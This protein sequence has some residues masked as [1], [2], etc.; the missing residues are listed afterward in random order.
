MAADPSQVPT[1]G[2]FLYLTLAS[3]A[4][5]MTVTA[6]RWAIVDTLHRR[7]GLKAPELDFAKL[8][9]R[10]DAFELLI[11][12]HYRHYQYYANMAV[13]TVMAY[14]GFRAHHGWSVHFG[15]VESLFVSLEILFLGT[16]RDTLAK[17]YKRAELLLGTR[18]EAPDHRPDSFDS[19]C[20]TKCRSETPIAR[21][22][23]R[24]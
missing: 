17:Y 10:V 2:G 1:I 13:A 15:W 23:R 22:N 19:N 5:G 11:E 20:S 8:N 4:C 14:V 9:G 6:I 24:S 21:R 12:I 3:I 16:S 7:T 18:R